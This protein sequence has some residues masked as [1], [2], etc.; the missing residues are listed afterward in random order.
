LQQAGDA[1]FR[2]VILERYALVVNAVGARGHRFLDI[3]CGPGR[4]GIE[5][6]RRG[7]PRCVGVDVAEPMIELAKRESELHDVADR[8]EWH[9]ADW[10]SFDLTET[11][12]AS[13]AMGY[14]DYV[15]NPEDH[16]AKMLEAVP[17]G[18]VFA[19]FPKRYEVRVPLRMAR[20]KL[21]NG[22]VRFYSKPEVLKLFDSVGS[23]A[24]LSL[25]DLGRDYIAIYDV[26]AQSRR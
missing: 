7:A 22:F 5:L 16:L 23:T 10:L 2:R 21:E 13:A 24:Y 1:A 3:G 19:S 11:F 6:A 4:Y 17:E 8:C 26:G 9:V 12:D 15:E 25:V 14:F 18:R 20:F